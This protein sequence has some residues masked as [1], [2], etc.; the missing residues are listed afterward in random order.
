MIGFLFDSG[1]KISEVQL[2]TWRQVPFAYKIKKNNDC[3]I[4]VSI[5]FINDLLSPCYISGPRDRDIK[6]NSS[7]FHEFII[8]WEWKPGSQ[9]PFLC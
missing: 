1:I 2:E 4:I 3:I 9:T 7:V 6:N 5:I 8:H